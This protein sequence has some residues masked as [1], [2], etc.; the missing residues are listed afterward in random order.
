MVNNSKL[1]IEKDAAREAAEFIISWQTKMDFLNSQINALGKLSDFP[2]VAISVFLLKTQLVE[3]ELKQLI[4]EIDLHLGFSSSSKIIRRKSLTPI[5][6]ERWTLGQLRD[7]LMRY[8]SKVLSTLQQDL[9]GLNDLRREFA[10]KLFDSSKDV[11]S[12]T[13]DSE[14]SIPLANKVLDEIEKV[15]KAL[16]ENDPLK[17]LTKKA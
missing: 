13:K 2:I 16:E 4:T 14:K 12:L 8:D 17:V 11:I 1:Q 7:H 15:K 9:K 10:H 6:M 5:E 3:F